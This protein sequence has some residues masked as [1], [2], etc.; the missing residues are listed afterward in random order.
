MVCRQDRT[1]FLNTYLPIPTNN[2]R[3]VILKYFFFQT[4]KI[5]FF[6]FEF[7][8]K[9][10]FSFFCNKAMILLY[11][12]CFVFS[13]IRTTISVSCFH[14]YEQLFLFAKFVLRLNCIACPNSYSILHRALGKFLNFCMQVG[15]HTLNFEFK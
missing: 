15:L 7:L 3:W 14:E 4:W 10:E 12:I 6:K 8:L 9:G 5:F 13:W 2:M 1:F 11:T